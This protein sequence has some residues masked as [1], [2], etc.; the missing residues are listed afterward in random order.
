MTDLAAP[1]GAWAVIPRGTANPVVVQNNSS[2]PVL[3][4]VGAT[5]PPATQVSNCRLLLPKLSDQ[6]T[7][8]SDDN[9]YIK[10]DANL[11]ALCN[12]WFG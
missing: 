5:A 11:P 8:L 1:A 7:V 2:V 3:I 9:I 6:L 4:F 10:S 12:I